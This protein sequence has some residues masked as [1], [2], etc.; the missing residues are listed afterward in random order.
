LQEEYS[1]VIDDR[2]REW[3]IATSHKEDVFGKEKQALERSALTKEDNVNDLLNLCS[4][5]VMDDTTLEGGDDATRAAEKAAPAAP[6]EQET[7][8]HLMTLTMVVLKEKLR[9]AGLP[10]SG[11]KAVLVERLLGTSN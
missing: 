3:K 5:I 11:T 6:K 8:S 1:V 10:V 9:D 4:Q 2:T 7:K